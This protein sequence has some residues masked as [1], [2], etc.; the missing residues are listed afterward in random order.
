MSA[1][2]TIVVTPKEIKGKKYHFSYMAEEE[3]VYKSLYYIN[4]LAFLFPSYASLFLFS[5]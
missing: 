2:E 5:V 4:L 1:W 3:F